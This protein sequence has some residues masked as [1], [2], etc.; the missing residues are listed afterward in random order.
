MTLQ[1]LHKI[2]AKW[3]AKHVFFFF[4][5]LINTMSFSQGKIYTIVLDAGHGGRDPGNIGF[6][7]YKE[8]DIALKIVLSR[9]FVFTLRLCFNIQG[10]ISCFI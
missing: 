8:K 4:M 2:N 9:L 3:K 6:K 10:S 5:I 1:M 7:K